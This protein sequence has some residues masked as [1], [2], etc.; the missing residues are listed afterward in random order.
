MNV[1]EETM[2]P[3]AI[4]DY[5]Y[6]DSYFNQLI[7]S[8]YFEAEFLFAVFENMVV[9]GV[10][11]LFGD[12]GIAY[13]LGG[14]LKDYLPLRTNHFLFNEMNRRAGEKGKVHLHLGGGATGQD[15][16]YDFELSFPEMNR[17]LTTFVNMYS[18]NRFISNSMQS[19]FNCKDY[20]TIS[21]S[22]ATLSEWMP[23]FQ[24]QKFKS[25]PPNNSFERASIF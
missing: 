1:Y 7:T 25:M 15:A 10:L 13:H 24:K 11:V 14:S 23:Y 18:T 3:L 20:L 8:E 9:V 22:I 4:G 2:I 5:C 17:F 21:Q 16:L 12:E 6:F 19:I